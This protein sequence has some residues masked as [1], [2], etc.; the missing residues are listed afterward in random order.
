MGLE[1]EAE[2]QGI[3]AERDTELGDLD[4]ETTEDVG[5]M[6]WPHASGHHDR[7]RVEDNES[8]DEQDMDVRN[9]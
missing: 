5:N 8:D 9:P 4:D 3:A 6:L 1:V 2:N 7:A